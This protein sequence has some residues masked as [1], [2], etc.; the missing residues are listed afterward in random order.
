MDTIV[1]VI[2][3]E[4]SM[5]NIVVIKNLKKYFTAEQGVFKKKTS[6]TKAVDD[7]SVTIEEG[8]TLAIVGES[9]SGKT[10][11]ARSLLR[12]TNVTSGEIAVDG[13]DFLKLKGRALRK[14][15]SNVSVVFQNP[16]ASLNPQDTIGNSLMRPLIV[17]GVKKADAKTRALEIMAK[18]SID[19][20]MFDS[21]P[22]QLSGGQQ[23]RISIARA[24]ISN[25]KLLVL[26]E[27]TSA[28]DI[29]VQSQILNL[30][31]QLQKEMKL[32][33][34]FIT[35]DLNVVKYVSD[36]VLVM[37]LGKMMEYGTV[38]QVFDNPTHP[39]TKSLIASMPILDPKQ[40]V[41][42]TQL[43]FGEIED[44]KSANKA[45]LFYNRCTEKNESCK[46]QQEL[47]D[48]GDGHMVLCCKSKKIKR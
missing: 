31:V 7:V 44:A 12:L 24:L 10:T 27:P 48:V 37:Y 47:V 32:T 15:R 21:F 8:T 11:L 13:K 9:G 33:Y 41:N 5:S 38:D 20:S 3:Q 34:L 40:R 22:H 36:K 42:R 18:V 29:S 1:C 46:A 30:L 23:Q 25:P 28:L 19:P 26:D 35:H 2:L 39:Y 17:Q 16:N 45:C 43:D 4:A 14:V 6:V